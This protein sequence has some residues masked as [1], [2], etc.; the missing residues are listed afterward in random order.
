MKTL[1]EFSQEQEGIYAS[2][3]GKHLL[4]ERGVVPEVPKPG[5]LVGGYLISFRHPHRISKAVEA[6]TRRIESESGIPVQAYHAADLHTTISDME[7]K[8]GFVFNPELMNDLSRCVKD[9]L[10]SF[11]EIPQP[12]INFQR[13]MYNPGA[14]VVA[15]N[16]N[17]AFVGISEAVYELGESRGINVRMPWGAHISALRFTQQKNPGELEPFFNIMESSPVIGD[18]QPAYIDVGTMRYTHNGFCKEIFDTF[19]LSR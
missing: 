11:G 14:V 17:Q 12:I 10:D 7:K 18:S 9:A 4:D 1:D 16:P 2:R 5:H 8:E 19:S 3:F 6:F 15:G 13:W